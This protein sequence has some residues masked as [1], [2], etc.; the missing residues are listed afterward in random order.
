VTNSLTRGNKYDDNGQVI[1]LIAVSRDR[2][3]VQYPASSLPKKYSAN[4]RSTWLNN[5]PALAQRKTQPA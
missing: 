5:D 1:K 4:C 3:T 2:Y